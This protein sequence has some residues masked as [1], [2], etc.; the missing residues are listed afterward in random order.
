MSKLDQAA[1]VSV[2]SE[3]KNALVKQYQ[4]LFE[5]DNVELDFDAGALQE[6]ADQALAR[7]TGARGSPRQGAPFLWGR[8]PD[9]ADRTPT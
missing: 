7:G 4:R 2:L 5:L 9:H 8:K 3:P 6:I 1:L